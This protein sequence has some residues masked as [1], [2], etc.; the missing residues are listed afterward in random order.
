MTVVKAVKLDEQTDQRLSDLAQKRD[1]TPHWIMR[2]ALDQYLEVEERYER[3]KEEDEQRWQN[4]LL[5]GRG[6][7][8]SLVMEWLAKLSRGEKAERP[9]CQ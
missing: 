5:T 7:D 3:E 9:Q 4:Y 8:N 6:V 1:R 2:E